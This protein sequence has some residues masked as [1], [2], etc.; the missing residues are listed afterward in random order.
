MVVKLRKLTGTFNKPCAYTQVKT[1]LGVLFKSPN[2]KYVT[3]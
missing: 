3:Q 2:Q 1:S